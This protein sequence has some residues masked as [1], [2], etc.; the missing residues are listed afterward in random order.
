MTERVDSGLILDYVLFP[1]PAVAAVL[2]LEAQAYCELLRLFL[3]WARPLSTEPSPLE[4]RRSTD[5]SARRNTRRT[6]QAACRVPLD[7][8]E[9]E[10]SRRMRAFGNHFDMAPTITLH[11]VEFRA[12][13]LPSSVG[14]SRHTK[15]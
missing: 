1:I 7:V 15:S 2:E 14:Q 11:G 4:P 13:A 12:T 6:Y 9:R 8:S 10:L 3:A 5:W